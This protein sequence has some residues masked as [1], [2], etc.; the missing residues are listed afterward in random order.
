MTI[1]LYIW[2]CV[3]L[4]PVN[5]L[6][7]QG[8]GK[9]T[10]FACS[11]QLSSTCSTEMDLFLPPEACIIFLLNFLKKYNLKFLLIIL[12]FIDNFIHIHNIL[13]LFS[14]ILF[15]ILSLPVPFFP[16]NLLWPT[17]FYQGYLCDCGFGIIHWIL[18]I[19]LVSPELKT[20]KTM[21]PSFPE[22]ASSQSFNSE[23]PF[24]HPKGPVSCRNSVYN[25]SYCKLMIL[26]YMCA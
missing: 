19:S 7:Q 10:G 11:A 3:W 9:L 18:V 26:M 25:H 20:L 14:L 5:N 16:M 6:P 2:L 23:E 24:T 8:R 22:S 21:T 17:E 4:P 13:R 1:F 12:L 15:S